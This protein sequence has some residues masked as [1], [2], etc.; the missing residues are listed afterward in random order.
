MN[1][2]KCNQPMSCGAPHS[3]EI[4]VQ[5]ECHSCGQYVCENYTREEQ[6]V[7]EMAAGGDYSLNDCRRALERSNY[8]IAAATRHLEAV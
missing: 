1:C 3:E 6:R 4:K 8:D 2:P 5:Y 7:N